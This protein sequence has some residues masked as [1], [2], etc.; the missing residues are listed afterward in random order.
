MELNISHRHLGTMTIKLLKK[1]VLIEKNLL[2]TRQESLQTPERRS[3]IAFD[4]NYISFLY[5]RD[6]ADVR[7]RWRV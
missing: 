6:A 3:A 1:T 4:I 5:M 7:Q 2:R